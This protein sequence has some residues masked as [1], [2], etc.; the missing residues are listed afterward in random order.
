MTFV[1]C[2]KTLSNRLRSIAFMKVLMYP[3]TV[4]DFAWKQTGKV[5]L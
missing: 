4:F 2:E 5:L 1:S 3:L